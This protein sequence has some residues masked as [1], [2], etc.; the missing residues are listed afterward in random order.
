MLYKRTSTNLTG[1][2][3]YQKGSSKKKSRKPTAAQIRH[4]EA[5]RALGCILTH[6][7]IAHAC[8]GR[9]TAHHIGTGGG[10][11]KNHDKQV[12]LCAA[13]HTGPDGIDGRVN[14]SKIDWQDAFATEEAMLEKTH[15]LLQEPD[16]V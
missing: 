5:V 6:M 9:I 8:H 7:G 4:R 12:A 10:S 1:R 13:M 15:Q 11:R 16:Y 2:P 14:Y 3:P